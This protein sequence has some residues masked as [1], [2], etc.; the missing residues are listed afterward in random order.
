M[1]SD[2][3][4][5]RSIRS[6]NNRA[7]TKGDT[8]V[9]IPEIT[10][11]EDVPENQREFYDS[12]IASRKRI[13]PPYN[14]LLHAP[15]L[16]ARTAHLIGYSLFST[17]I[18]EDVKELAICTAARELDCAYEWAAHAD[19]ARRAGVR[20]ECIQ[21]IGDRK[22]PAGLAEGEAEVVRYVQELL[23]PPHRIASAT[24]DALKERIGV[25]RLVELT[26]IIAAYVGLACSLNA[27]EVGTPP[28]RP[29]LPL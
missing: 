11:R 17:D 1:T 26:G 29:I 8:L 9:R 22:A 7:A 21:I 28:G 24:F 14:Y 4:H 12:I 19:L 23:R 2:N 6:V 13:G 20:E 27:F 3:L 16:A 10:N 18:P 25:P 5:R 15:D